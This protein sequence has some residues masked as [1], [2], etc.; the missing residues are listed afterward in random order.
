MDTFLKAVA[1]CELSISQE[2]LI[3]RT[4]TLRGEKEG[5]RG[6][7]KNISRSPTKSVFLL[8]D[9]TYL[10]ESDISFCFDVRD[11]LKPLGILL[12]IY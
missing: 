12:P 5:Q 9:M 10:K 8:S 4:V 3:F 7:I 11:S 6:P 1:W 2:D